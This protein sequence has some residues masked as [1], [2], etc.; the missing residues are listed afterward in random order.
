MGIQSFLQLAL[1]RSGVSSARVWSFDSDVGVEV[2]YVDIEGREHK[3][4]SLGRSRCNC[5]PTIFPLPVHTRCGRPV[6]QWRSHLE[7]VQCIPGAATFFI[8]RSFQ[9]PFGDQDR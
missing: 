2:I 1:C 7:T 5:G 8:G 6:S 9:A 3:S 4:T